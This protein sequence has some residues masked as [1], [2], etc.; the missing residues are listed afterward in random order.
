M[1]KPLFFN[2]NRFLSNTSL[3]NNKI[4]SPKLFEALGVI[5]KEY[6]DAII[7]GSTCLNGFG[8]INRPIHDIDIL[9]DMLINH[10]IALSNKL[11]TG[12]SM[13]INNVRGNFIV[14]FGAKMGDIDCCIFKVPTNFLKRYSSLL[15]KK[16]I[17][18]VERKMVIKI[19]HFN[20]C[21]MAKKEYIC[22]Q[23]IIPKHIKDVKTIENILNNNGRKNRIK[24]IYPRFLWG[25]NQVGKKNCYFTS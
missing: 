24:S 6:P 21:L 25:Q 7:G 16:R 19:Q 11:A 4:L 8:L 17:N 10:D 2:K 1:N 20:Y 22:N 23:F 15:I 9:I 13:G 18:G 5:Y 3:D 12:P 14:R